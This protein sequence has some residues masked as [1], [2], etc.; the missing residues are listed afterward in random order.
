M[1]ASYGRGFPE[2]ADFVNTFFWTVLNTSLPTNGRRTALSPWPFLLRKVFVFP[3]PV[4]PASIRTFDE[5]CWLG[6]GWGPP[7]KTGAAISV[8]NWTLLF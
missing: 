7:W 6:A 8:P 1:I 5:P 4:R 3:S 2:K